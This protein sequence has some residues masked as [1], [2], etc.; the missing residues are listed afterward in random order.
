MTSLYFSQGLP[1]GFFTALPAILREQ[2]Y[3]LGT[4]GL[5]FLL[6]IPWAL[7][8]LWAPLVD[9]YTI[10]RWG[11]RRTWIIPLQA[12]AV[13]TLIL[14]SLLDFSTELAW[15]MAGI[16]LANFLAATQDIATDAL[17]VELLSYP[18]RGL[19]NGI[20]VAAYRVGMIVGGGFLISYLADWGWRTTFQVMAVLLAVA[21][22][23]ILLF[24]EHQRLGSE[25]ALD[26]W[27]TAIDF[28]TRPGIAKWLIPLM[29]YKAGDAMGTAMLRPL[30]VD[31]GVS[32][33]AQ[34]RM[35]GVVGSLTG[36]LGALAGGWAASRWGRRPAVI[37][38][39]VFQ[40]IAVA[41][42]LIPVTWIGD[43]SGLTQNRWIVLYSL[44]GLE[45]FAGG[46]A[47]VALFTLMMDFCRPKTAG[48][49]YTVQASLVVIATIGSSTASGRLAERV[50]YSA[51]FLYSALFS[52]LGV[53][54]VWWALAHLRPGLETQAE[55]PVLEHADRVG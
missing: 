2:K 35:V 20:Q 25:R 30:L 1:Y 19:G 46:T 38:C 8:C 51:L 43:E 53:A 55:Q 22:I 27:Q 3:S 10:P 42:Y 12:S 41:S 24:R 40:S 21:S 47:T 36:L 54:A 9:R 32:V 34:G 16:L 28:I 39:G 23:P 18:E 33:A 52:L 45:H 48:T 11:A 37:Y 14:M 6:A 4:I 50:G 31:V 29:L 13:A 17:A 44:C 26:L 7:K 15:V 5:S 49:D